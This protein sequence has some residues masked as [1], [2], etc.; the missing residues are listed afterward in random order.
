MFI[1]ARKTVGFSCYTTTMP[2]DILI[3]AVLFYKATPQK[4]A[5]LQKLFD[6]SDEALAIA[7][8]QLKHRLEFGAVRLLETDTEISLSTA[9]ELSEFIETM[10]KGEL[11]GDIGK[12]GA[13]T[14]AII[15]YKEPVSRAEIDRV[16]GVNSSFI[17]RNL[18]VKGLITR[19]AAGNSYHFRISPA[20]LQHLGVSAK[21][22]LSR[23]SEF[24][25]AIENFNTTPET[26]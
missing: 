25:N 11:K 16:R 8:E 20:L 26:V 5:A 12:A 10:R 17:L 13:E 21:S 2:L 14:L 24:M 23:F 19:E 1:K 9:P 4:K 15:L 6:V 7:L 3:E 22:E 18:L